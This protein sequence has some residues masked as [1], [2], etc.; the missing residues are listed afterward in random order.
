MVCAAIARVCLSAGHASWSDEGLVLGKGDRVT[1]PLST[2]RASVLSRSSDV[3]IGTVAM[4]GCCKQTSAVVHGQ[5]MLLGDLFV[6]AGGLKQ[7]RQ[8]RLLNITCELNLMRLP[9]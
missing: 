8:G 2:L 9:A 6:R 3:S 5:E 4:L 7:T 1:V